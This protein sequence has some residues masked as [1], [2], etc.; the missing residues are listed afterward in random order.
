[1]VMQPL[2]HLAAL[3]HDVRVSEVLGRG[4]VADGCLWTGQPVWAARA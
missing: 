3:L 2:H 4:L 1:M